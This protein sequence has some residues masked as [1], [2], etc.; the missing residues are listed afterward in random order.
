MQAFLHFIYS[1][2][3][4]WEFILGVIRRY[5]YTFVE[6]FKWIFVTRRIVLIKNTAIRLSLF[7]VKAFSKNAMDIFNSQEIKLHIVG[8][9][10]ASRRRK[11]YIFN[12]D[13]HFQEYNSPLFSLTTM[14]LFASP[15]EID[16]PSPVWR[17]SPNFSF[18]FFCSL[19]FLREI[20]TIFI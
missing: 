13:S 7:P 4:R 17:A 6:D 10:F 9:R 5:F 11:P 15:S 2:E 19:T 14:P 18:L 12:N 20:T 1:G 8:Q 16:C 3:I